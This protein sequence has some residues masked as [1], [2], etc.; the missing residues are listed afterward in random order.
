MPTASARTVFKLGEDAE[1]NREVM[2]V[3]SGDTYDL[4]YDTI[5]NYS[6]ADAGFPYVA[7]IW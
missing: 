4:A 2:T 6:D 3:E 5:T 7:P 1:G